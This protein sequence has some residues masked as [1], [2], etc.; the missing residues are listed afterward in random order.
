MNSPRMLALARQHCLHLLSGMLLCASFSCPAQDSTQAAP[1]PAAQPVVLDRVIAVVNGRAI[2]SSDLNEEILLSVLEPQDEGIKETPQQALER[3]IARNLIRQQIR[4]EDIQPTEPSPEIVQQRIA[5]IRKQ[6]PICVRE[7]CA[8]E[9]GWNAFLLSHGLTQRRV[10]AYL[11]SRTQILT[12]IEMRFRQG[13]R[14]S[15]QETEAYYHNTLVPQYQTGQAVPSLNDVAPR[16]EEILLQQKVNA[17]F[18]DWLDS[19]RKQGDIE[20][21]DPS[22]EA[23][24]GSSAGGAASP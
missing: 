5:Q 3:L 10:E 15:Q 16:I 18:S 13:I 17:M 19:L 24:T 14:I 7:N 11:R 20:V 9:A 6:Q 21:M 22:L 2:L 4:E 23:A 8:T 12:F 1:G